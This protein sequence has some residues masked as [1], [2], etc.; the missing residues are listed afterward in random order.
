MGTVTP[1]P[2]Q[3]LWLPGDDGYLGANSDPATESGGGLLTAG[4]LY[5]A[6]INRGAGPI[7]NI[8]MG[9]SAVGVGAST[10]S[11][12]GAYSASGALLS[13]SADVGGVLAGTTGFKVIGALTTPQA[14]V[15]GM[16][17]G[18]LCN[19]ATTQVTMMRQ[20]NS[21]VAVAQA[22][23]NPAT[24]RWGQFP[25]VGTSLPSQLTMANMAATAFTFVFLWT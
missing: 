24:L 9:I 5:V 23:A 13:G 16:Y 21:A 25:A 20:A 11:F 19:L 6:R 1:R 7:T 18:I 8:H 4:T 2:P 17:L 14:F 10:G 3:P 15:P 12:V 22:A